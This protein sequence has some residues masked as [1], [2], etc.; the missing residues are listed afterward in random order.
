MSFCRVSTNGLKFQRLSV[1]VPF[2]LSCWL[3]AGHAGVILTGSFGRFRA[4]GVSGA[5]RGP[6]CVR[7]GHVQRQAMQQGG[8]LP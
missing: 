6:W 3:I 5:H 2:A 4:V 7:R 1:K 8:E